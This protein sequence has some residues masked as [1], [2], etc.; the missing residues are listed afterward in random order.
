MCV[1]AAFSCCLIGKV[2][3]ALEVLISRLPLAPRMK[4]YVGRR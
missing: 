1:C 3:D 2:G 4:F